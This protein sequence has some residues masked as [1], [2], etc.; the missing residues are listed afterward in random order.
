M[1]RIIRIARRIIFV[2]IACACLSQ[3]FV[4]DARQQNDKSTS[5]S[6]RLSPAYDQPAAAADSTSYSYFPYREG[7]PLLL[8]LSGIA[9]FIGATTLK[10]AAKRK[11][12]SLR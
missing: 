2:I 10:K 8:L 1:F 6:A 9:I 3:V 7:E 11:R 5:D 4:S 12:S